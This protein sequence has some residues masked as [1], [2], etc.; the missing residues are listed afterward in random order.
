MKIIHPHSK[1][2]VIPLVFQTEKPIP[3]QFIIPKVSRLHTPASDLTSQASTNHP[4][5]FFPTCLLF[6]TYI[7]MCD[8]YKVPSNN[9]VHGHHLPVNRFSICEVSNVVHNIPIP[10]WFTVIEAWNIMKSCVIVVFVEKK[11][12]YQFLILPCCGHKK[13]D[14][15]NPQTTSKLTSKSAFF[16]WFS[17]EF[18]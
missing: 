4:L 3:G 2:S 13:N 6:K 1:P 10:R 17:Q 12:Q 5:S 14:F 18:L 16:R 7:Y 9:N 8:G 15:A 11:L